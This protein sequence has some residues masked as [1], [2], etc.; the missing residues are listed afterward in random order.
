MRGRRSPFSYLGALELEAGSLWLWDRRGVLLFKVPAATVPARPAR[1][2]SFETHRTA[3]EVYADGR[4]WFLVAHATKKYERHSTRELIE[5]HAARE[6]APRP[7]NMSEETY[8]KMVKHPIRHQL[9]WSI[10]WIQALAQRGGGHD[11]RASQVS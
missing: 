5:R 8:L 3:F 7:Q 11:G 2:R 10:C 6:L 4:W 9:L 1:R